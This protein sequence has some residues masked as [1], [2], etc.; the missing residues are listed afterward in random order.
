M[1]D[2][3]LKQIKPQKHYNATFRKHIPRNRSEAKK[4]SEKPLKYVEKN[5]KNFFSPRKQDASKWD[6]GNIL[7]IGGC[8]EMAGAEILAG[9]SALRMGSGIVT[10]GIAHSLNT[11]FK[12]SIPEAIT[13][14]LAQTMEGSIATDAFRVINFEK[15]SAVAIG[16]GL[17][18]N[19]ATMSFVLRVIENCNQP[20][21]VDGDGLSALEKNLHYLAKKKNTIIITPHKIE[22]ARLLGKDVDYVEKNREKIASSFALENKIICVLKG[23]RTVVGA[24]DGS[25]YVNTTGNPSMATAGTG[26]VLT[27]I[28]VSLLGQNFSGM[29]AACFGVYLHGLCGDMAKKDKTETCVIASDLIKYLPLAV[30]TLG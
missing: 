14:T 28:I 25:V 22:M 2:I 13:L 1:K 21:V 12:I 17:S 7:I 9:R 26:D 20:L 10:L 19:P 6:F 15:F 23:H 11:I 5:F 8:R 16:P 18:T 30:K 24:P 27:G 3:N 29:D 4:Y